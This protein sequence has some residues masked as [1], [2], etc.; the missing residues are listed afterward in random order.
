MKK[1]YLVLIIF[2]PFIINAQTFYNNAVQLRSAIRWQYD[3]DVTVTNLKSDGVTVINVLDNQTQTLEE[4]V[5]YP[6]GFL[7]A[8]SL[9]TK[10][11]GSKI[12]FHYN[13]YINPK[14]VFS[15]NPDVINS[16]KV[17]LKS[18]YKDPDEIN[19]ATISNDYKNKNPFIGPILNNSNGYAAGTANKVL[20]SLLSSAGNLDVTAF[21]DALAQ[22]LVERTKEE[23][24]EA[25]FRKFVAF[26]DYYPEFKTLFPNT[27]VFVNNFN[28]WEYANL[29]NTLREAFDKDIKELLS[30][31]VKLKGLKEADCTESDSDC[32]KELCK[33]CKERIKA[34]TVFLSSNKGIL[35]LS[36]AE[37][38]NG[39]LGG[40]KIPD[41]IHNV[42]QPQFLLSYQGSNATETSNIANAIKLVDI[43]SLS[44]KSNLTGKHYISKAEFDALLTDQVLQDIFLGLLYQKIANQNIEFINAGGTTTS[45]A[46][47][48]TPANRDNIKSYI[49]NLSEHAKNVQ[50][51]FDKLQADKLDGK[52]DLGADYG[53]I[54]QATQQ[55]LQAVSN[56]TIIS[57]NI[58]IP[59]TITEVLN[60]TSKTL[61]IAHDIA[62][63][64]YNAAVIGTLKLISD[65]INALPDAD[66][67][68]PKLKEF[69]AAFLKYGSFA[70]NVVLSKDP[71]EIKQ[72]INSFALPAGSSSVKKH[73]QFNISLNAYTG[74]VWGFNKPSN[75]TYTTKDVNGEDSTV[76]LNGGHSIGVYAPVGVAFSRGLFWKQKDPASIS[77]FVSL[78]DIGAIVGYRFATDTGNISSKFK[79]SLSNIFAPGGNLIIGLPNMPLSIGGG[80]QWIPSLQRDPKSNE[81]Y[82]IDHS[83][84][85]FQLFVAVD[86]PLLNLHTS[87]QNMLYT[88]K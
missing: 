53:A 5:P 3:W 77:L 74:F 47:L 66:P 20:G 80:A 24:N 70:A 76:K 40:S 78:I 86:L 27:T 49:A 4:T 68:K 81:F 14:I 43:L 2:L 41:I 19:F 57:S 12:N 39:L 62:V 30:N 11:D 29:L 71:D 21:A 1:A 36:S 31:L 18:F 84:W 17:I 13:S 59:P 7:K 83:A 25:F 79:V 10:S 58:Q 63:R 87:K 75:A 37:I 50:T 56:V 22:F 52:S 32:K 45:V 33:D 60:V 9:S 46:T 23:L 65:Q 69:A 38:G 64:N 67:N 42:A 88:R 55:A 16:V 82:N 8:D 34:L 85:R 51:T 6:N 73:T 44:F 15:S 72:A 35:L 28:S 26:L 54:F 48:I 61:Q